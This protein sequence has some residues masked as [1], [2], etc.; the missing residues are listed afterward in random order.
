META[1]NSAPFDDSYRAADSSG[2]FEL[3]YRDLHRLARRQVGRNYAQLTLGATTLLHEAYL[4]MHTLDS[5]RF[6]EPAAFHAYAAR[7]MRGMIIDRIR[8]RMS[9][10]HGGGIEWVALE[11][12]AI[13]CDTHDAETLQAISDALDGLKDLDPALAEVVDLKFFCGFSFREIAAMRNVSERTVQRDWEKAR[14]LLRG[15]LA[16]ME[17]EP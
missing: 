17:H 6:A 9:S 1:S 11:D 4:N 10:K 7:M 5:A 2:L 12:H 13:P 3:L 8:K 15:L 16:D 14:L